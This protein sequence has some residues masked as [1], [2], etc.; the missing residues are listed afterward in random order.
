MDIKA[1]EIWVEESVNI[2]IHLGQS[3][4]V[5]LARL[6]ALHDEPGDLEGKVG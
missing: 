2:P 6:K 4:Y 1:I 5:S 3:V